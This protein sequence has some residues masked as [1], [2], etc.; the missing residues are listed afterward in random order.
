[1]RFTGGDFTEGAAICGF[2]GK[3]G[4]RWIGRS[5]K[6]G[7]GKDH[8]KRTKK[9]SCIKRKNYYQHPTLRHVTTA[10]SPRQSKCARGRI[11]VIV[12]FVVDGGALELVETTS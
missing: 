11:W 10:H 4:W 5:N 12:K 8:V 9:G 2:A 7:Y 3:I 1:M 6:D